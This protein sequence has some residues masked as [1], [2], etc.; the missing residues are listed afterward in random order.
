[1]SVDSFIQ[2]RISLDASSTSEHSSAATTPHRT[3][4]RNPQPLNS[5]GLSTVT[6]PGGIEPAVDPRWQMALPGGADAQHAFLKS[7]ESELPETDRIA[8]YHGSGTSSTPGHG[9]QGQHQQ[10]VEASKRHS[11]LRGKSKQAAKLAMGPAPGDVLN[12]SASTISSSA[13]AGY[14]ELG[15]AV[16][17]SLSSTRRLAVSSAGAPLPSSS[18]PPAASVLSSTTPTARRANPPGPINI[19]TTRA[20][21]YSLG[22]SNG[23]NSAAAPGI[24]PTANSNGSAPYPPPPPLRL[25]TSDHPISAQTEGDAQE[26]TSEYCIAIV[27]ALGCGKTMLI[28][29][30]IKRYT[31][32]DSRTFHVGDAV[33]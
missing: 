29:K 12:A 30:V 5:S 32:V 4:F 16:S 21:T 31:I 3:T 18:N 6:G 10:E 11:M 19:A 22:G 28:K 17:I 1:M 9:Q 23:T 14:G 15:R 24:A 2:Q 26:D 8:I 13:S 33:G 25:A 20:R 27:G 7:I